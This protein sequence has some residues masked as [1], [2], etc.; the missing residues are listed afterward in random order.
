MN[1]H[2]FAT[3]G[4]LLAFLLS[5]CTL[6]SQSGPAAAS[7]I[8]SGLR[9]WVDAP[10]D[11]TVL[12]APAHYDVVCHGTDPGGVAA[13]EFSANDQVLSTQSNPSRG[14][15]L[16]NASTLWQTDAAG[17]YILR[18][19]TQ[20]GSGEWSGYDSARVTVLGATPGTPITV[21]VTPT[22]TSTPTSSPTPTFTPTAVPLGDLTVS[23]LSPSTNQFYF[24]EKVC[25]P[26]EVTL[27]AQVSDPVQV[28]NVLLFFKLRDMDTGRY[29][30][31]NGGTQMR[32]QGNGKF[33]LTLESKSITD[34]GARENYLIYQF[35]ATGPTNQPVARS[36]VYSD[37]VLSGCGRFI[38]VP[39]G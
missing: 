4:L 33:S 6:P 16:M 3:A 35:V 38:I 1:T 10:L 31:W 25:G 29:T 30:E 14:S 18:C 27:Q 23:V 15:A 2:Q 22:L 19:R 11:G 32:S 37:I 28:H 20:A 39:P 17:E 21:T 26:V 8:Y 9:A 7:S 12:Y 5:S 36:L 13:V 34:I 24:G